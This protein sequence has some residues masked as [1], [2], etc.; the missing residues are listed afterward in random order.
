[1]WQKLAESDE[2][3][4]RYHKSK[5]GD[6]FFETQC[7]Y[8]GIA[9]KLFSIYT[10]TG[11]FQAMFINHWLVPCLPVFNN[12][13]FQAVLSDKEHLVASILHLQ[14][15]LNFLPEYARLSMKRAVLAYIQE[16]ADEY[17]EDA[18]TGDE[19]SQS[20]SA[21]AT[22]DDEDD[23]Y[24]FMNVAPQ[25]AAAGSPV[26][27]KLEDFLESKATSIMSLSDYPMVARAFVK[28]NTPHCQAVQLLNA[29]SMFSIAGIVLS[30]R[31]CKMSDKRF[32][33]VFF[34]CRRGRLSSCSDSKEG[35]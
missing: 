32:D 25:Q 10:F 22:K 17:R 29:C 13:R 1:L 2:V 27:K 34:K 28:A 35:V 20:T 15:K 19:H 23:L 4:Q 21:A 26:N 11:Y 31:R 7:S 12:D 5:N 6:V 30:A 18:V 33:R 16:V 24:S 8:A 3:C 9:S 14:F